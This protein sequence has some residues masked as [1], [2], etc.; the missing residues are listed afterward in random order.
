MILREYWVFLSRAELVNGNY[1]FSQE[2]IKNIVLLRIYN[3]CAS[4]IQ[5]SE[6]Q[7]SE[8]IKIKNYAKENFNANCNY[9]F[10]HNFLS[11]RPRTELR[12]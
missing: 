10:G 8:L 2:G 3:S 12:Y 11:K 1:Y 6:I 5:N 9:E 7:K 4:A